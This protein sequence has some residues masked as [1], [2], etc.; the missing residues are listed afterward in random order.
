MY[1]N[2]DGVEQNNFIAYSWLSLSAVQGNQMA[3]T[4]QAE[5]TGQMTNREIGKVQEISTT[6]VAGDCKSKWAEILSEW[7]ETQRMSAS[8]LQALVMK[9]S[10]D[11]DAQ[12]K[13]HQLYDR[14][15][16]VS[17]DREKSI[18]WLKRAAEN[19]HTGAQNHMG[20]R[21]KVGSGQSKN[22]EVANKWFRLSAAQ[23]Y[24]EAQFYLGQ[25]YRYGLG[26]SENKV[27]A[28]KW[29]KLA[30]TQGYTTALDTLTSSSIYRVYRDIEP[31]T[32]AELLK[33]TRALAEQGDDYA[34]RELGDIYASGKGVQQSYMQAYLWYLTFD[35]HQL[36]N[37]D[38][39]KLALWA[40]KLTAEQI[41]KA[42]ELAKS[43]V[44]NKYENCE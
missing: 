10:N 11:V 27:E 2:G 43:C 1:I 7:Q 44:Q 34:R 38:K 30:A 32:D 42:Q 33:W 6:C 15:E 31:P 8:E 17:R 24:A 29:Y 19:G 37:G 26:V 3:K 28:I 40:E 39:D 5:L 4:A 18:E 25:S 9:A 23:G 35:N 36:V 22:Y 21:A 16:I 41:A 14:G 12:Y 13:L 20:L